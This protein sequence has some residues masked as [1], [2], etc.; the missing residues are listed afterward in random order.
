MNN[1]D[2][3]QSYYDSLPRPLRR[4]WRYR[5]WDRIHWEYLCGRGGLLSERYTEMLDFGIRNRLKMFFTPQLP[6]SPEIVQLWNMA[7]V[8]HLKLLPSDCKLKLHSH[9]REKQ[10]H[11]WL[12]EMFLPYRLPEWCYAQWKVLQFPE[13]LEKLVFLGR[14]ESPRKLFGL[15]KGELAWFGRP[16]PEMPSLYSSCIYLAA[17]SQGCSERVSA[18]LAKAWPVRKRGEFPEVLQ[19]ARPVAEWLVRRKVPVW[20]VRALGEYLFRERFPAAG[21]SLKGRTLSGLQR[22]I[23]ERHFQ[24]FGYRRDE[25]SWKTY[26]LSAVLKKPGITFEELHDAASLRE[27]G[28][29]L[30]HCVGRYFGACLRGKS[31]IVSM[32][33]PSGAIDLTLEISPLNHSI[34]Q[35]RGKHNQLPSPEAFEY[36][37]RYANSKQLELAV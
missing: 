2:W 6:N 7:Q 32:R 26:G 11:Q 36:V 25:D 30:H 34:V 29:R 17:R 31:A 19:F 13:S 16:Q 1:F 10:L 37:R 23:E 27:E 28:K 14:G 3:L 12:D 5:Q 4:R 8:S 20:H 9:N 22:E 24:L 18:E 15:S 33:S 21:F 35:V